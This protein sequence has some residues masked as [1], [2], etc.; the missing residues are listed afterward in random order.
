MTGRN[1]A[2]LLLVLVAAVLGV[3][4]WM[5]PLPI[6]P[7]SSVA[8]TDL[9]PPHKPAIDLRA[10][11]T[12]VDL[13]ATFRALDAHFAAHGIVVRPPL[14]AA[15]PDRLEKE[16]PC[17]LPP[18]VRRMYLWH[19]GI[20]PMIPSYEWLPLAKVIDEYRFIKRI[21]R[22]V[23]MLESMAWPRTFLP[24]LRFDGQQ[25]IAVDCA[26]P[27]RA[28]MYFYFVQD[29]VPRAQYRG[30]GHFLAVTLTAF[31][32]KAFD[33]RGGHLDPRPMLVREAFQ[34]H[35]TPAELAVMEENW[36]A[37]ERSLVGLEGQALGRQL[38][39]GSEQPDPRAIPLLERYLADPDPKVVRGAAFALG[40]LQAASSEPKLAGLLTHAS[41]EVRNF[42][43][44]ALSNMDTLAS[45]ATVDRLLAMLD[46]PND[47]AR[48]SAINALG[49]SRR[50][51]AVA[52]LL[53]RLRK[54]RP[55]IEVAI[56]LALERIG[57]RSAL[58]QLRA[59]QADLAKMDLTIPNRGGFRGS[60]PP[61]A[62]RKAAVEAAIAKI[63]AGPTS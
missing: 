54:V 60:D 62:S 25:H 59:L 17:A 3:R 52:P 37:Y 55:G 39:S 47:L 42:A 44:G 29:G 9:P 5:K 45:E 21:E 34:R 23:G 27:E 12:I 33:G 30:P 53:E 6:G 31:D 14:D 22:E 26:S 38:S 51:R 28:P 40:Q 61:P 58:P 1:V 7:A 36:A 49:T 56:V 2:L 41:P 48:L 10:P 4:W 35:A 15:A 11:D 24:I 43:A 32:T 19:D 50:Q 18:A 57:D 63:E 8:V 46:D 13:D 20:N 16:L